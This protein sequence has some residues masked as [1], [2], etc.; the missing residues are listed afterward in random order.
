MAKWC[1]EKL[2]FDG[3][4]RGA[5]WR[6]GRSG[7][8]RAARVNSSAAFLR[9][10]GPRSKYIISWYSLPHSQYAISHIQSDVKQYNGPQVLALNTAQYSTAQYST[11]QYV[12]WR[13]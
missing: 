11:V 9:L 4:R 8:E 1:W 6:G 13:R 5:A 3:K 12:S 7:A 2:S 10:C